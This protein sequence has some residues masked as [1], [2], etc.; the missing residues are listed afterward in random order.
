MYNVAPDLLAKVLGRERSLFAADIESSHADLR[1]AI[2]GKRILVVGAAGSIGAAFVRQLIPYRPA[3]L[4]LIDISEN[5]LVEI[6]RELRSSTLEAP[7]DFRTFSIGMG[8]P[9]FRAFVRGAFDYEVV[10]N[11]AALKHVRAERDPYSLL[12]MLNTNFVYLDDFLNDINPDSAPR[13]VFSVSSDKSVNPASLLG[14]SKA[15]MEDVLRKHADRFIT[16]SARFA[17]VAFSAGSLLESFIH[18][19][20]KRQPLAAPNDVRR[21]FISHEEAGELCLLGAFLGQ[22]GDIVFPALNPQSDMLTFSQIALIVLEHFGYEAQHCDDELEARGAAR[23][24]SGDRGSRWPVYFSGSDTS[25]EKMFEEF[26]GDDESVVQTRWDSVGVVTKSVLDAP[27]TAKLDRC[28]NELRAAANDSRLSKE[29]L[30]S[31]V[32]PLM[33]GLAHVETGKNLDD[34][35]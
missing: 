30:V 10:L 17:N 25:G 18:R 23:A 24:L 33:P 12:R 6:V 14:A 5:G 1:D 21:F 29:S 8:S 3:A 22:S 9:E 32:E 7:Q 27:A 35:M 26:Y 15:L 20:Q 2:G 4:H 11:F 34:K 28:L 13:R 16:G 19:L 31:L